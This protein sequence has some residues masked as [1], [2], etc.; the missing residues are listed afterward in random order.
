V[1]EQ[2]G[3]GAVLSMTGRAPDTLRAV[4]T[5][6]HISDP[7]VG[8]PYFVPNLMNRVIVELNELAPDVIVNTGDLT[9]EGYRQEYKSWCAYRD[10]I[11]SPMLTV[12]GNH[13]ARNV[14]YLH[15][16]ELVG[17]RH[18]SADVQ[19][20]RIV[21]VDSSEPDINDGQIG[22]ERYEWIKEQ[23][24]SR[25]DLKVF[26]LHHHLLPVPG[27]G[28]ER[29]VVNDAGDLLEVLI[30]S[31]VQLVLSGHKHVPYVWRLENVYIVNAGT[32]SSL[33][34]RG[35][36]KPCYNIVEVEGDEVRILRKFPF[37]GRTALAHF[38]L[39]TGTQ[40]YR[41]LESLVQEPRPGVPLAS[42]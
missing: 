34:L 23:F 10:R 39:S 29:S 15:F 40:F 26:A 25:A 6:A 27:T 36:T 28:R 8:S 16:E 7:H 1:A 21:G 20:V 9:N 31:G 19:G 11:R 22:R 12:T 42:E 33:R 14:G 41:E 2:A 35:Y 5:I 4:V 17:P 24:A 13:D 30:E 18:W 37:G 3:S 38:S 32:C